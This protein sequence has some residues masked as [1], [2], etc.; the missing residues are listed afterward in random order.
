MSMQNAPTRGKRR[1]SVEVEEEAKNDLEV[2]DSVEA[3]LVILP[4][5]LNYYNYL[6]LN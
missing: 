2:D 6:N 3:I 4:C 1:R 5:F